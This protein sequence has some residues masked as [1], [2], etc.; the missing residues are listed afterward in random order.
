M[1]KLI[2][3]S[4]L[5]LAG[6]IL[7][8]S[9]ERMIIVCPDGFMETID[10]PDKEDFPLEASYEFYIQWLIATHCGLDLGE[11]VDHWDQYE[12]GEL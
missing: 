12:F 1:K 3:C 9:A 5:L 4:A 11:V 2:V 8:A 10:I 6:S 7:P